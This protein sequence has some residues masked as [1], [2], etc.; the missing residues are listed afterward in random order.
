[1][2]LDPRLADETLLRLAAWRCRQRKASGDN[3]QT[4][5]NP[6]SVVGRVCAP[7][8]DRSRWRGGAGGIG[9]DGR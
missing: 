2:T 8:T 7:P 1:M 5:P 4:L 9:H 3:F 6:Q